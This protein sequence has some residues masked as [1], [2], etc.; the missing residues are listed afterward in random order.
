VNFSF[1]FPLGDDIDMSDSE[2]LS[3]ES[4]M[5]EIEPPHDWFNC[6][7]NNEQYD[8]PDNDYGRLK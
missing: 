6:A 8:V 5:D 1:F 2:T 7:Q 3:D 4:D